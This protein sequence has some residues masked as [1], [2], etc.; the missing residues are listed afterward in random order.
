MKNILIL[1]WKFSFFGDKIFSIFEYACFRDA[2]DTDSNLLGQWRLIQVY[3][4]CHHP[5]VLNTSIA[6]KT[7]LFKFKDK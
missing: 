1:I 2:A 3:T 6:I 7:N 5:A 4:V